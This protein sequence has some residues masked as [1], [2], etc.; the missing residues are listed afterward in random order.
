[1]IS[2]AQKRDPLGEY[3]PIQ[4]QIDVNVYPFNLAGIHWYIQPDWINHIT[5]SQSHIEML[6]FQV[7]SLY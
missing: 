7:N 5:L 6:I 3:S 1:M 2:R 4:A